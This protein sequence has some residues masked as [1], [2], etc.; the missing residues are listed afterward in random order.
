MTCEAAQIGYIHHKSTRMPETDILLLLA[1]AVDRAP[2]A[3]L[4]NDVEMQFVAANLTACDLL[5]Y[6]RQEL[7]LLAGPD[8]AVAPEVPAMHRELMDDGSQRGITPFRHRDGST[9]IAYYDVKEVS[10]GNRRLFVSVI[11]PRR[12]IPADVTPQEFAAR[13]PRQRRS[14][15]P[16]PR[17]LDIL[18]LMADGLDN[19]AIARTLFLARDTVK[20]NVGR[21]LRKLEARSRTHA[22]AI[23]LRRSLVD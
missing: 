21:L 22:V 23:A 2:A 16:T 6:T 12:V 9:I 17:E 4:V 1:R 5:G 8:V 15:L 20:A 13:G 3:V 14:E 7:L 18:Q 10:D 11:N 19:E